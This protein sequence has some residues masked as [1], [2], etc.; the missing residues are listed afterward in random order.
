MRMSSA[1]ERYFQKLC[2]IPTKRV[3]AFR[4]TVKRTTETA[5]EEV[6]TYGYHRCF[7]KRVP[8]SITG[9]TGRTQGASIVSIPAMKELRASVSISKI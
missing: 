8:A 9:R 3:D 4:S 6:T 5:S 1:P 7:S 2:G